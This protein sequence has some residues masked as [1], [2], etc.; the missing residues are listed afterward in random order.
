MQNLILFIFEHSFGNHMRIWSQKFY[1]FYFTIS[2]T[3]IHISLFHL[4]QDIEDPFI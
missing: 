4:N 3:S 2:K 1:L